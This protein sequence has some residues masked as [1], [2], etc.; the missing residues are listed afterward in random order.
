M[1]NASKA[2]IMAAEILIGIMILSITVYLFNVFG[3]YSAD[4]YAEIEE[5]RDSRI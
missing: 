2:L 4:R 5:T 3:R 1:E